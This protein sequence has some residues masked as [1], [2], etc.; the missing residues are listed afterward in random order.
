MNAQQTAGAPGHA[1]VIGG[2]MAGMLTAR[3]LSEHF[4]R[5][6][7]L[8]RDLVHD[9]PEARRGQPQT[10][11]LHGLL[12]SGLGV[13]TGFFPGLEDDLVAG[14]AMI[15]D[16]AERFR[17]YSFGGYRVR[18]KVGLSGTYVSRPFLEWQVRRRVL[19]LA[20]EGQLPR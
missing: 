1:I 16:F 2:S 18:T 12:A 6:T 7:I 9:A 15:G 10:R 14:G 11:H 20:E 3:V 17:W 13:L 4:E 8:E 19:A 5:V